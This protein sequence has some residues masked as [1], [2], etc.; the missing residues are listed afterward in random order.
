MFRGRKISLGECQFVFSKVWKAT[1][2]SEDCHHFEEENAD[3][4]KRE[5][6]LHEIHLSDL[7]LIIHHA[8]ILLNKAEPDDSDETPFDQFEK[9]A[10]VISIKDKISE[11]EYEVHFVDANDVPKILFMVFVSQP[12]VKRQEA[13]KLLEQY[14]EKSDDQHVIDQIL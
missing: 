14:A 6:N 8:G 1:C 3:G 13:A 5:L 11:N 12:D 7:F 2:E 4:T 9:Y 10:Q